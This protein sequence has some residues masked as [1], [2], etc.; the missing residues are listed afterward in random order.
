MN[1]KLDTHDH[2]ILALLQQD[3]RMPHAEIGRRVH[4]SQ[5]AVSERIKRLEATGVIRGYHA[6]VD[7]AQLGYTITALIRLASHQGRPYERYVAEQPEVI[8]CLTVT[9]EDCAVLKV[10]ARDVTHLQALIDQL[11]RYGS[12][13][14][15]IVLSTQVAGKPITLA[16]P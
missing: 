13:S 1:S 2:K 11:N 4:L 16:Q 15:A 9:G 6:D 3:A 5:P 7:P 12:T 14:T 10:L 8:E